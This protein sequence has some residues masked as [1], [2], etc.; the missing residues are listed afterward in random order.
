MTWFKGLRAVQ[1][2]EIGIYEIHNL[3]CLHSDNEKMSCDIQQPS[4]GMSD[5]PKFLVGRYNLLQVLKLQ[6]GKGN[7][8]LPRWDHVLVSVHRQLKIR[9]YFLA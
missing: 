2:L 3:P 8:L 4:L 9:K 6:T 7:D 1:N 5:F